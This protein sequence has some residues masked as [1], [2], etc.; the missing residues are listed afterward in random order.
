MKIQQIMT[1]YFPITNK[2]FK[3]KLLP[4]VQFKIIFI[5]LSMLRNDLYELEF[6]K[7]NKGPRNI[8]KLLITYK[9]SK[10]KLLDYFH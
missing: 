7:I 1:N 9:Q 10:N 5:E 3:P 8:R 6:I 2:K 4:F